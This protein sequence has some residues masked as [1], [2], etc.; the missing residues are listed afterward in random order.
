[1]SE[2]IKIKNQDY[3]SLWDEYVNDEHEKIRMPARK[4]ALLPIYVDI[5]KGKLFRTRILSQ[6]VDKFYQDHKHEIPDYMRT[7]PDYF[8][9][10]DS[11]FEEYVAAFAGPD[12][13]QTPGDLN[14]LDI[15]TNRP[16]YM[17]FSLA[18]RD[19]SDVKWRFTE[20]C[21]YSCSNDGVGPFRNILPICTL[22]DGKS[23]LVYNRHRSDHQDF[24]FNLHVTI[25]QNIRVDGKDVAV[26]TPIIIDPGGKNNGHGVP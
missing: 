7:E 9:N 17:L 25:H 8:P 23:L 15:I 16:T 26:T 22:D 12:G 19:K 20:G 1:M 2:L 10:I 14:P 11:V 21:P 4:P 18:R 24:K 5:R 13:G 6:H 3:L